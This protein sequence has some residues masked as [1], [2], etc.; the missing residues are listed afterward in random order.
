MEDLKDKVLQIRLPEEVHRKLRLL[1]A[2][3]NA[4]LNDLLIELVEKE[5]D[6][7]DIILPTKRPRQRAADSGEYSMTQSMRLMRASDKADVD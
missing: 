5:W 1:A 3:I 2:D 4:S 6:G 7:V